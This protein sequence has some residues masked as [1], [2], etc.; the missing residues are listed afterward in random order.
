MGMGG[1]WRFLAQTDVTFILRVNHHMDLKIYPNLIRMCRRTLLAFVRLIASNP[2]FSY[3]VRR[4]VC[5]PSAFGATKVTDK[6]F[7]F[8]SKVNFMDF[9]QNEHGSLLGEFFNA[10]TNCH[11]L[12]YKSY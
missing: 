2:R 12:S 7:N 9:S 4:P 5:I 8:F 1:F 10:T 6:T 11:L 3:F